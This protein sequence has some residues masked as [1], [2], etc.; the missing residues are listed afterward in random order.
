LIFDP[1]VVANLTDRLVPAGTTGGGGAGV[2][3]DAG[4]EAGVGCAEAAGPFADWALAD[5]SGVGAGAAL[6]AAGFDLQPANAKPSSNRPVVIFVLM[7]FP[8]FLL[9]APQ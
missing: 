2:G 1:N 7:V 9:D 6:S 5:W 4:V 3:D 8:L